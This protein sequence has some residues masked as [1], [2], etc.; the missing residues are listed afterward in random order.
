MGMFSW[1]RRK[2]IQQ[3]ESQHDNV[4][5][6]AHELLSRADSIL[7]KQIS[8]ALMDLERKEMETIRTAGGKANVTADQGFEL[9]QIDI[10][11]NILRQQLNSIREQP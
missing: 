7:E 10:Q 5:R 2:R 8:T 3:N 9:S 1:L 11:R 4:L 6:E